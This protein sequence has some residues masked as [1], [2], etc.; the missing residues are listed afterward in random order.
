MKA[1]ANSITI[2]PTQK[3]RVDL[4]DEMLDAFKGHGHEHYDAMD[5]IY[6]GDI[7]VL[8][9]HYKWLIDMVGTA[10]SNQA[11]LDV[12][13]D[14]ASMNKGTYECKLYQHMIHNL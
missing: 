2:P 11:G 3:S 6:M 9:D 4:F 8:T 12:K 13:D 10:Q 1:S 7:M 5:S 14:K